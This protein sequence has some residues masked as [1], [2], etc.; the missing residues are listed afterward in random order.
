VRT[1]AP[2]ASDRFAEVGDVVPSRFQESRRLIDDRGAVIALSLDDIALLQRVRQFM[3]DQRL[4]IG[5]V[6]PEL[7]APE[8][9]VFAI[10]EG[11]RL[12]SVREFRRLRRGVDAHS[13]EIRKRGAMKV[14]TAGGSGTPEPRL[15]RISWPMSR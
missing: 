3:C 1:H 14:C 15:S 11:A 8:E 13:G 9:D 5:R 10:G 4:P 12:Q 2:V 7:V 6:R